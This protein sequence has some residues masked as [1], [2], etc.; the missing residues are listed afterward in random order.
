MRSDRVR[1]MGKWM[2]DKMSDWVSEWQ[3]EK[4]NERDELDIE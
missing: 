3:G 1:E 4:M 2:Y